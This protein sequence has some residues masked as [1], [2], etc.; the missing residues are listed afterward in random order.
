MSDRTE[1]D[2]RGN[3]LVFPVV[4]VDPTHLSADLRELRAKIY[5]QMKRMKSGR[6]GLAESLNSEQ[7]LAPLA[8]TSF[9]PRWVARRAAGMALGAAGLPIGCSDHGDIHPSVNRPDGTDAD[10]AYGRLIEPG[11]SKQAL[12]R[13]GGQLLVS[14]GRINGKVWITINAF[15][16]GRTNTVRALREDV[17]RTFAEFDL[18]AEIQS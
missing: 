13:L 9:T 15:L 1:N 8:L 10:Y 2:T 4:S 5:K 17:V 14:S 12:E 16:A 18:A 6:S 3:A 11:I 7:T